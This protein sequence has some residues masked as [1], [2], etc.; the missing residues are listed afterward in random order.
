MP[1]PTTELLLK[2][3]DH[4]LAK[5]ADVTEGDYGL[6]DRRMAGAFR[7]SG[8]TLLLDLYG[9][10]HHHYSDF[11]QL[12]AEAQFDQYQQAGAVVRTVR[13]ELEAGWLSTTRGLV[14][15]SVFAD[16]LEMADHLQREGYKDAAAVIAGS[17]LEAHLRRLCVAKAIPVERRNTK[18][19]LVPK[20]AEALNAEL[21]G[22]NVY[23]QAEQKQVTAWLGIRNDAAHG[24]YDKVIP[25][26]V[27]IMIHGI[28]MFI[29]RYAA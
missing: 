9:T 13:E 27:G 28:R 26:V 2:R 7:S 3:A 4:V 15:G 6:V 29:G 14:A 24:A 11:L 12:T 16:F 8:L 10:N 23:H 20:K 25:D 19:D 5:L 18:G 1:E 22:I 17:S 21:A